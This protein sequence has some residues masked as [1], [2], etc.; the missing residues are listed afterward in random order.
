MREDAILWEMEPDVGPLPWQ[1]SLTVMQ[2]QIGIVIRDGEVMDVFSGGKRKLPKGDV[3]TYVA[4]TKPFNLTFW[5]KEPDDSEEQVKGVALDHPVL[6]KD[7]ELVTGRIDLILSVVRKNVEYLFHLPGAGSRAVARRDVSEAI[8][9]ELTGKVLALDISKY[10]AKELR[11]NEELLRGI[12]ESLQVEMTST[13]RRYGLQL[14]NFYVNWGLTPDE[15]DQ[16]RERRHEEE[17]REMER[18]REV[19]ERRHQIEDLANRAR[20]RER[21]DAEQLGEIER[22]REQERLQE[23]LEEVRRQQE[24]DDLR[25]SDREQGND[26]RL[27]EDRGSDGIDGGWEEIGYSFKD[28]RESMDNVPDW[29]RNQIPRYNRMFHRTDR[30]LSRKSYLLHEKASFTYRISFARVD[31]GADVRIY[32]TSKENSGGNFSPAGNVTKPAKYRAFWQPLVDILRKEGF[33][34]ATEGGSNNSKTFSAPGLSEDL[35]YRVVFA[36]SGQVMVNLYIQRNEDAEW[37]KWLFDNLR[38]RKGDIESKLG[39]SLSWERMP[40]HM[41]CRIA[42]YRPGTIYDDLDEIREWVIEHL[43][44]FDRV[45]GPELDKLEKQE[46]RRRWR[47]SR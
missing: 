13:I 17:L 28:G 45:F 20:E 11:G 33:T 43:L 27:E 8:E 3:R 36:G 1:R 22:A 37:N 10:T 15:Q 19:R 12:Y 23:E 47:R 9:G 4:S 2:Y 14:D 31:G 38:E 25:E 30:D 29:V 26:D 39:K 16:I 5:L 46:R 32:R 35:S 40:S 42:V 7:S 41:A 34:D 18:E 6:T 24:I 44:A 21:Q